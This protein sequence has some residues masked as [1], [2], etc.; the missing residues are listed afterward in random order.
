[1]HSRQCAVRTPSRPIS[2]THR[3]DSA[4]AALYRSSMFSWI[5]PCEALF[6]L[7]LRCA[8]AC[9]VSR[10]LS[11]LHCDQ[12]P[13]PIIGR[14]FQTN[15][16]PTKKKNMPNLRTHANVEV[17]ARPQL[18]EVRHCDVL[19]RASAQN[20]RSVRPYDRAEELA[21]Q[22]AGAGRRLEVGHDVHVRDGHSSEPGQLHKRRSLCANRATQVAG[23]GVCACRRCR[24]IRAT[25]SH[26]N[27][28]QLFSHLRPAL[29]AC[30]SP[31][32]AAARKLGST[33]TEEAQAAPHALRS[34]QRGD[35]H[36][37]QVELIMFCNFMG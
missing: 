23:F 11:R 15:H 7:T 28:Q 19:A 24:Y 1:M 12:Q 6:G 3:A 32:P 31:Q 37:W 17:G 20:D 4:T 36:Q 25:D 27:R 2:S 26:T 9:A 33:T 34:L 5:A 13:R 22:H 21:A 14:S 10:R 18:G 8:C 30:W 29:T 35:R 16:Q